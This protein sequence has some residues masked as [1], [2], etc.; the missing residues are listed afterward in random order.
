MSEFNLLTTGEVPVDE[1]TLQR[2]IAAAL[3]MFS[4]ID[5]SIPAQQQ[6]ADRV[7]EEHGLPP[8]PPKE[9][10]KHDPIE[11][12]RVLNLMR[13]R[14]SKVFNGKVSPEMV[15]I[16]IGY[17]PFMDR[18]WANGETVSEINPMQ[19]YIDELILLNSLAI[20]FEPT[21]QSEIIR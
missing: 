13:L 17:V 10:Q 11:A 15:A 5:L 16:V 6:V 8:M 2:K 14:D 7:R 18:N 12:L 3:I 21:I 4:R 1:S 9:R 19:R 20:S